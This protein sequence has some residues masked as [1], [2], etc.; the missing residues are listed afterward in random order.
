MNAK[1]L[2]SLAL[3]CLCRVALAQVPETG[4][5]QDLDFSSAEVQSRMA[6]R[7]H[8]IVAELAAKGT[9]DDDPVMQERVRGITARLVDA[10]VAVM[11]VAGL[12]TWEVHT[13]SD[14]NQ[15]ASCMAGGKLLVGIKYVQR[16]ALNDAELATLLGHEVAHAVAEHHREQLSS[17]LR[18]GPRQPLRP[19]D[20][21]ISQLDTDLSLQIRLSEL[22]RIQEAEADQLGMIL[23]HHAGWP[24]TGMVSF[25]RKLAAANSPTFT[26]WSHPP[27]LA[28]LRMAEGLAILFGE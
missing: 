21:I 15:E 20:M 25:Y 12:W 24:A 17:V 1:W 2:S 8:E 9:L 28:R 6:V 10:A 26:D 13:T 23:A 16:L 19:L 14:P 11:P 4:R 18:I 3:I 5:W 27:A 22:S 7:Y